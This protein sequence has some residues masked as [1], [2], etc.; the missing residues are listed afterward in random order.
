MNKRFVLP[1][2]AVL[3]LQL[4]CKKKDDTSNK[5]DAAFS[6]SGY[7]VQVPCTVT[8]FNTSAN[9]SS[10]LWSFGDGSTSTEFNPVHTFNF[11]GTYS[12]K[13]KVTGPDGV[14]SVCKILS[15]DKI[16]TGNKSAFSYFSD[17]CNGTPVGFSFKT[18]N[19]ASSNTVWDFGGGVVNTGRDPIIQF[20]I[21]GDYTIKYSTQIG[22]IRDT[23]IRIIR[24]E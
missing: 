8:F 16:P 12:I 21:A 7:E 5:P 13:L 24:V 4:S 19:P 6:A 23:V 9:A 1:A 17:K 15:L 14:D 2:L 10:Y 18:L 20:L 11:I 3:L 22:G